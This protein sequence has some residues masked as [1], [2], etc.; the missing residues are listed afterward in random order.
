VTAI[1]IDR[2]YTDD[3]IMALD[4]REKELARRQQILGRGWHG[5]LIDRDLE[6]VRRLQARVR[7]Q[8]YSGG[9]IHNRWRRHLALLDHLE[10]AAR[11]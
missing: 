4:D 8:A 7:C 9:D 1:T 5:G 2:R 11:A 6:A 3:L 10:R